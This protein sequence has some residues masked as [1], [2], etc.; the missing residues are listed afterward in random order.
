FLNTSY[1]NSYNEVDK[2]IAQHIEAS[3]GIDALMRMQSISRYGHI[4]FYENNK[5]QDTLCYHTDIVYPTKLREQIKGKEIAYDRGTDGIDYWLWTG[6]KYEFTEDK[7]LKD[8]MR[9]TAER[10]NREILWI[11]KES[12]KFDVISNPPSWAPSYSQCIQEIKTE[13]D[14]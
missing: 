10:A 1:A 14:I 3:G 4:S 12:G 13:N 9:N 6:S 2:L 5:L 11:K 7:N 8:Y